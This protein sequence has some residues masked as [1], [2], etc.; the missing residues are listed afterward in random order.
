MNN[1]ELKAVYDRVY[2]QGKESFFSFPTMD[3]SREVV[4]ELSWKGKHVLE[5]GCGTGETAA[6][7]AEAGATVLA[8]DY[9][10]EAIREARTRHEH[11]SLQFESRS[12]DEVEGNFDVVVA[13]EVI[14]HTDEPLE[15]LRRLKGHLRDGGVIII[16]CPSFLNLRG[17]VWMTL[18]TLLEVPMSLTDRHFISP[19]DV[20]GWAGA[21][22]LSHEFRTFRFSQAHG[23]D[24]IVDL[25][26][27]LTNALRDADLDNSRVEAFLEWLDHAKNYVDDSPSNGAKALYRLWADPTD[28]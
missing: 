17:V 11:P 26:K 22:G 24:M 27:R 3:I 1:S 12:F 7:L 19:A 14:E 23:E 10:I 6:V 2:A 13:Q 5:I 9:S 8:V 15:F 21:L 20:E 16:T 18:A 4:A 28:P 25:R